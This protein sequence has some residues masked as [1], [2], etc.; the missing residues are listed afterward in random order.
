MNR[1]TLDPV[2]LFHGFRRD[3]GLLLV[4]GIHVFHRHV[5]SIFPGICFL[6]DLR[7]TARNCTIWL[8]LFLWRGTVFKC[9]RGLLL[10]GLHAISEAEEFPVVIAELDMECA[11]A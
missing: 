8:D 9:K 10:F 7:S 4:Y 5:R 2:L 3:C 1:C 11:W 6:L